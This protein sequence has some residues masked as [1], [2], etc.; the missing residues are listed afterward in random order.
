[1]KTGE[2][3][4]IRLRVMSVAVFFV[5]FFVIITSKAVY[6]QIF[7]HEELSRR[8][9]T[10]CE[11]TVPSV[12][13][14]GI[15]YDTNGRELAVS[16]D[17]VKSVAAHPS[18]ITDPAAAAQALG[19]VLKTD[20]NLLK[21]KLGSEKSFVW[22]K[23]QTTPAETEA[24]RSLNIQGISLIPEHSRFYPNG[25]L[26]SQVLGF[27]G[28]DGQGLGGA[29]SYYDS[30][31]RNRSGNS[32]VLIDALGRNFSIPAVSC[33]DDGDG[34]TILNEKTGD[35]SGN[36]LILTID[37]TVQYIAES[38]LKE[39]IASFSA[40]SGIA[41]VMIPDTGAVLALAHWPLFNPNAFSGSDE[42]T[43]RNRAVTDP[44]EPGSTMKIF[45]AAAAIESGACTADTI[46]FCE[47]GA[48]SVGED[49]VHDTHPYGWL[50][51]EKIIKYSSNIGSI[52][53]GKMIGHETLYRTLRRFGFGEKTGIDCPGETA[54]SLS[55]FRRWS[56]ID[57]GAISFGHGLSVSAIQLIAAVSAIANDGILMKPYIVRAISDYRGQIIQTFSPS[58]VRRAISSETSVTVKNMMKTVVEKGGTGEAAALPGYSV[59]GKTGTAQKTDSRGEYARGKYVASFIGFIIAE[60]SGLSVVVI[61]DEPQKNHYGGIVAAPAFRSIAL[62]TLNYMNIA[63]QTDPEL[64][65]S[66]DGSENRD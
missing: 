15:I 37:R 28:I 3:Q 65:A 6:L 60:G 62:E 2:K 11:R 1:M 12:G 54:G 33:A 51:L 38:A 55:S 59:Y 56:E 42:K 41:A 58:K 61:I 50:S 17:D 14:R 23:R 53:V 52:K 20:V 47:K 5:I 29:E 27:T 25:M 39:A 18:Y 21:S 19:N 9:A 26:A 43:R 32:K 24:V 8:A 13:K 45:S 66:A 48:Y 4:H 46:F 64:T 44:F 49:T 31:L 10:Q 34:K 57:A 35:Y 63:P 36:N 40:K 7:C 16:V 30:Y 22:I